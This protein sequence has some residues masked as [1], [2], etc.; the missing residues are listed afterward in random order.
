MIPILFAWGYGFVLYLLAW[1]CT[2]PVLAITG[3]LLCAWMF[4]SG[5][6]QAWRYT[7]DRN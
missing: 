4:I 5:T 7:R 6:I 1:F 3:Y 2:V